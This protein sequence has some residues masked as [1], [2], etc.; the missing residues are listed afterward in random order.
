M[1]KAKLM[2]EEVLQ[3]L[4]VADAQWQIVI[5]RYF[6]PVGAHE[7]G[8]IGEDPNGIPNN[9]MPF[10]SQTAMGKRERVNV[11]G[12]DYPTEDGTGVRDYI[13]V[14]DLATGH[15]Q[16]LQRFNQGIDVDIINLGTG[17]GY[18]VKQML[19]AFGQALRSSC[20]ISNCRTSS[21]DIAACW[22]DPGTALCKLNWSA[23]RGITEMCTD[24]WRWQSNNP[25]GYKSA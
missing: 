10:I 23:K 7:S 9:L 24:A 4:H 20:T 25:N 6:N 21:R 8:V 16:A 18:S 11:F 22:A 13:H 2:V 12:D 15:L 17:I 3:D 14:V 1:A 5:L 19:E